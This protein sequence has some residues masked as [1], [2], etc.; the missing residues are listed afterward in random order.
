VCANKVAMIAVGRE[1][2]VSGHR[3][4]LATEVHG[5]GKQGDGAR[6]IHHEDAKS[7]KISRV[8]GHGMTQ[9]FT[10]EGNW[11]LVFWVRDK[12]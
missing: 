1:P 4:G 7:A 11:F 8:V 10:E 3:G 2:T 5:N 12:F 6:R 9:K